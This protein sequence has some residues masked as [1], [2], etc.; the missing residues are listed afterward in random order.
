MVG[1]E[2]GGVGSGE[3]KEVRIWEDFLGEGISYL[4]RRPGTA[5]VGVRR[6]QRRDVHEPRDGCT[7]GGRSTLSRRVVLWVVHLTTTGRLM[8]RRWPVV[9]VVVVVVHL[10]LLMVVM[11]VGLLL[12]LMRLMGLVL[13]R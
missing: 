5:R 1:V 4:Q 6:G 8:V 13:L 10:Q 2:F 12:V 7:N 3:K 9:I 11:L